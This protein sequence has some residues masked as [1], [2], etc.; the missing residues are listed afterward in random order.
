MNTKRLKIRLVMLL[1]AFFTQVFAAAALVNSIREHGSEWQII[2]AL[3]ITSTASAI[4][5]N[6]FL[7]GWLGLASYTAR[8]K[9][10]QRG[11]PDHYRP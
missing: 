5:L 7:V 10:A 8:Q 9:E 6:A 2:V 11:K 1:V 4:S 3:I